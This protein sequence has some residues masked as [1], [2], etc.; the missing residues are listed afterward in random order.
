MDLVMFSSLEVF[1]VCLGGANPGQDHA[2]RASH[3]N[4]ETG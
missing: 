2:A 4:P 1:Y 3:F